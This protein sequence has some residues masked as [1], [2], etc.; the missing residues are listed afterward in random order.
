MMHFIGA[1]YF[2][3]PWTRMYIVVQSL[4]GQ[5]GQADRFIDSPI[6]PQGLESSSRNEHGYTCRSW[7]MI[8]LN[9]LLIS[10]IRQQA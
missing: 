5:L 4:E 8:M 3:S 9:W 10:L 2:K 1:V 7:V 6:A